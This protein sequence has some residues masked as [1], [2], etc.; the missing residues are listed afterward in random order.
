VGARLA[1]HRCSMTA[2]PRQIP[3]LRA[4]V[5]ERLAGIERELMIA[6]LNRQL[7]QEMRDE[8][9]KRHPIADATFL[10]SYAG[11]YWRS[12]AMLVR[13]LADAT[14]GPDSLWN[15]IGRIRS[16]PAIASRNTL[17][18]E[19]RS[20]SLPEIAEDAYADRSTE[21]GGADV[22]PDRLLAEMQ[23][24]LTVELQAVTTWVTRN[25]AHRDPRGPLQPLTY[26]EIDAALDHVTQLTNEVSSMLR[27][28]RTDYSLITIQG[29]WQ[30]C[31]RPALF[32]VPA[33]VY[34]WP[35]PSGYS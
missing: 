12:Q 13:R 28:Q 8:I 27:Y 22:P 7:Y 31:F 19:V 23:Q 33:D 26:G 34:A 21:Y 10:N 24:S 32:A 30:Q 35:D 16:N 14:D 5:L 15:L 18:D 25:V 9:L 3:Q 29:D 11:M 2:G 17:V 1:W 4:G 6:H 20:R